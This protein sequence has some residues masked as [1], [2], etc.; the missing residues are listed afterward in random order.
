VKEFNA[1]NDINVVDP[2]AIPQSS[3]SELLF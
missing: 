1:E 2:E 3:K